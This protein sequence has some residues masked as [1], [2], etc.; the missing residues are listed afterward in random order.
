MSADLSKSSQEGPLFRVG[1]VCEGISRH[2]EP[3]EIRPGQAVFFGLQR[4]Q[5]N[6]HGFILPC[7]PQRP[8]ARVGLRHPL[9]N[10]GLRGPII[11]MLPLP[12]CA[13]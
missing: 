8:A 6:K 3:V 10:L 13:W 11:A 9:D 2:L 5:G 4:S 1:E 12:G 7:P